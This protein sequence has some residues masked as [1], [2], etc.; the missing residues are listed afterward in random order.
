MVESI[1]TFGS[2][3]VH[4]VTGEPLGNR[5]VAIQAETH[6]AAREEMVRRWDTRWSMQYPDRDGPRGAGV[7]KYGLRILDRENPL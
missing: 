4:P 5:F 3:H 6:A 7:A 1:F 2:G